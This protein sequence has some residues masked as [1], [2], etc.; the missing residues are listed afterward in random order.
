[1]QNSLQYNFWERYNYEH[2]IYDFIV[3]GAGFSGLSSAIAIKNKF[4]H[5]SVLIIEKLVNQSMA[6][7]RNA[8]FLCLGSPSELLGDIDTLTSHFQSEEKAMTLM[9]QRMKMRKEGY[10]WILKNVDHEQISLIHCGGREVFSTEEKYLETYDKLEKLRNLFG[11][12][13]IDEVITTEAHE[14]H[15]VHADGLAWNLEK[16]LNPAMLRQELTR[17]ARELGLEFLL[18][19]EVLKYEKDAT[20]FTLYSDGLDIKCRTFIKATNAFMGNTDVQVAR[21]VILLTEEL[22]RKPLSTN[23]HV[24]QGYI[25]FRSVGKRFLI[26]GGRNIDKESEESDREEFNDKIVQY[27][28]DYMTAHILP[29]EDVKIAEKWIGFI[30]TRALHTKFIEIEENKISLGAYNGIG[31]C[32]AISLGQKIVD[33]I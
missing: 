3:L 1:M 17:K 5:A 20:G 18:G 10:D 28:K 2:R 27:L 24:D 32:T 4:P 21:N 11:E 33:Y 8:G 6:S 14:C 19:T 29:T 7:T 25:Y 31:V 26:G 13:H 30:G 15:G 9:S 23:Y 12:A 16:Q 22:D